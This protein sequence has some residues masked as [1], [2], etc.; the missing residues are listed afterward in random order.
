VL[1][2]LKVTPEWVT[3]AH[4]VRA[5][6]ELKQEWTIDNRSE[7]L[8]RLGVTVHEL[9]LRVQRPLKNGRANV[10]SFMLDAHAEAA[11]GY[12]SCIDQ[13]TPR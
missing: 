3:L 1:Q 2:N 9:K 6:D 11:H 7:P 5:G 12:S 8:V 13:R 4:F 10:Y